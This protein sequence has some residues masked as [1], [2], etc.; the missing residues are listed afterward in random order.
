MRSASMAGAR[1]ALAATLLAG[2]LTLLAGCAAAGPDDRATPPGPRH[3]SVTPTAA[4]PP[5]E[6][7]SASRSPGPATT[8]RVVLTRSGGIAGVG[9]TV[10]VEH[11]GR[12][13]VVG[14]AGAQRAGRLSDADL[15][16]LRRLV[17]DPGL[18]VEA[19]RPSAPTACRD[20]F[21][22]RLSVGAVET[23]YV[24]CPADGAAPA[25]TRALVELLLGATG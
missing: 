12:W 25:A 7:T 1:I 13:T 17:A 14:R 5:P 2:C 21:S 22:Y 11:D 4:P 9:N 8:T 19:G 18:T 24:D 20:A 10:T 3:P 15:D 16:R 23:G 6:A